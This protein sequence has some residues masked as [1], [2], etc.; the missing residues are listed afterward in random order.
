M[1]FG[2]KTDIDGNKVDFDK[3]YEYMIK[4][5]VEGAGLECIRCDEIGKPG[6]IHRQMIEHIFADAVA[7]VD[8]ST[9]NPNVFYELGVRQALRSSTTILIRRKGTKVPFNIKGLKVIDYDSDDME[10]VAKT[11]LKIIE[12]IGEGLKAETSDSLVHDVLSLRINTQP[13]VLKE[14]K[15]I[16]YNIQNTPGKFV[17][18]ITG[19]IQKIKGINIWVNSENTNMQMARFFDLSV[20]S[21]IRYLGSEKS[22]AGV[23][24]KD[25]IADDLKTIVGSQ[26][27]VP[28]ATIIATT[29]GQLEASHQVKYIFHAASVSGALGYGYTPIPNLE[30]CVSN[31]LDLAA[32]GDFENCSSILFPLMGTGTARGD[33]S[34]TVGPLIDA[35]IEHLRLNPDQMIKRVNFVSRSEE[36]LNACLNF[37]DNLSSV[38]KSGNNSVVENTTT[39]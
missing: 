28:P 37:L 15:T 13:K 21:V 2:D 4:P 25:F 9:L 32:S 34:L 26:N 23:V 17:C 12:Y 33:L 39:S 30:D 29:S 22:P 18:I 11:K 3:I 19:D 5:P 36:E 24:T 8:I 7:V 1:P 27:T 35:A 31:S 38:V 20:S 14:T 16:E 6:S 10:S